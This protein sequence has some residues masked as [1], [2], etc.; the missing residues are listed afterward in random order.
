MLRVQ[1]VCI[2]KCSIKLILS[3]D[4]S[5]D[6]IPDADESMSESSPSTSDILEDDGIF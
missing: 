3:Q 6:V 1:D 5:V 4:E 2:E